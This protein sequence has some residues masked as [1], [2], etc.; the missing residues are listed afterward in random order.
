MRAMIIVRLRKAMEDY[1]A[2]T[3][4]RMTYEK[5]AKRTGLAKTTL[6]SIGTRTVYNARLGTIEKICAALGC[7]PATLL[8]FRMDDPSN[9][10]GDRS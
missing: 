5:L 4:E 1:R 8:E 7:T 9:N 10:K 6:E 2:R 3:G